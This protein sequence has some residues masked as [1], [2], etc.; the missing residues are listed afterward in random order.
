MNILHSKLLKLKWRFFKM[1]GGRR[2]VCYTHLWFQNFWQPS[3][4]LWSSL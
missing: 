4:R 1:V 2:N 3:S